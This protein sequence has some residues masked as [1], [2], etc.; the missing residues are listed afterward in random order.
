MDSLKKIAAI[1]KTLSYDE[2]MEIAQWYA[3]WTVAK[4]EP[5]KNGDQLCSDAE[6]ALNI[7]DWAEKQLEKDD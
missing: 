4:D 3:C 5:L 6:M 2:L 1:I 7:M